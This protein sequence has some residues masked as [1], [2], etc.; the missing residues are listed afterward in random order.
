MKRIILRIVTVVTGRHDGIGP[1]VDNHG[2]AAPRRRKPGRIRPAAVSGRRA[3]AGFCAKR[4]ESAPASGSTM[5]A[6]NGTSALSRSSMS[7]VGTKIAVD[8]N[9][10]P[11]VNSAKAAL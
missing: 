2:V 4:A 3:D 7:L 8:D 6:G 11:S 1:G 10:R 9:P 5:L